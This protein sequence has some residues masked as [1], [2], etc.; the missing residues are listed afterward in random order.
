MTA[1]RAAPP[2]ADGTSRTNPPRADS[3]TRAGPPA[4]GWATARAARAAIRSPGRRSAELHW[5]DRYLPFAGVGV[6]GA[7]LF[8]PFQSLLSDLS[9]PLPPAAPVTALVGVALAVAALAALVQVAAVAGPVLLTPA[10]A[11]WLLLS[12]LDRRAVLAPAALRAAAATVVVGVVLGGMT[13]SLLGFPDHGALR[14]T[15]AVVGGGSYALTGVCLAA[16]AQRS[17]RAAP[18]LRRIAGGAV[19]LALL[20]GAT[21]AAAGGAVRPLPAVPLPAALAAA[22]AGVLCALATAAGVWRS[23]AMFPAG[24]VLEAA[25]R[26][27]AAG[28]AVVALEPSFLSRMAENAYWRERRPPSRPW[29]AWPGPLVLAWLDWRGLRRRPGRL[30]ALALSTLLPVLLATASPDRPL[31]SAAAVFVLGLAA[32]SAGAGGVRR[33]TGSPALRRLF[34]VAGLPAEAARLV[35]PALLAG[36]WL[37]AALGLLELAGALP[38]EGWCRLGPAAA[39]VPALAALRMARRG[40]IDHASTPVVM[41]MVGSRIPLGWLTWSLSGLDVAVPGLLPLLLA[42]TAPDP[43]PARSAAIQ[44]ALSAVLLTAHLYRRRT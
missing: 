22:G 36:A 2:P 25:T 11:R 44:A 30:A 3:A 19:V 26:L 42:L 5:S 21:V 29:P 13:L 15:A 40:H 31:L 16:L 33:E 28:D 18:W 7:L 34:G 24:P 43:D 27:S 9:T 1:T 6:G 32:A 20:T 23:L 37:T 4:H 12:P 14:L 8:G 17:A 10:D 39:G 38:G 35:L 41:P